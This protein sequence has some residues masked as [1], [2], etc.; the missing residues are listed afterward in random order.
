MGLHPG[1]VAS[2]IS[3]LFR[4]APAP[5]DAAVSPPPTSGPASPPPAT[6]SSQPEAAASPASSSPSPPPPTRPADPYF[7]PPY[8]NDRPFREQ[9]FFQR[10][11][12]F[13]TKHMSEGVFHA[14]RNHVVSHLEFGGCLADYPGLVA[15]YD[16]IRALED[17]DDIQPASSSSP[18]SSP[19]VR[20]RFANYYTLSSGYPKSPSC[21]PSSTR[22]GSDVSRDDAGGAHA[23]AGEEPA[24]SPAPPH[25]SA[26]LLDVDDGTR[27]RPTTPRISVEA[28]RDE[29]DAAAG[30]QQQ[31]VQSRSSDEPSPPALTTLSIQSTEPDPADDAD[32][33][34]MPAP[35]PAPADPAQLGSK[36]ARKA[37][38]KEAKQAQRAYQQAIKERAKA[39]R[40]R[41]KLLHR[42]RKEAERAERQAQKRRDEAE[43]ADRQAQKKRDEARAADERRAAAPDGKPRKLRKFCNLPAAARDDPAWI[44]VYMDGVDEVGAHCGLFFEGPHYDAL[45]GDVG[46]RLAAWVADDLSRRVVLQ[47]DGSW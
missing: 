17:V 24:S 44:D 29:Q 14:M 16:A 13:T 30:E 40:A 45:V 2:G 15:R 42:R 25:V 22:R 28:P 34:P 11:L 41:E 6:T 37:A 23:N 5:D 9:P 32:L 20:V 46:S 12:H 35:P 39:V 4:P 26:L 10:L 19:P 36:E 7:D 38:D 18:S 8:W 31:D 33:P 43:R 27:P 21:S 47:A 1:I 3:S